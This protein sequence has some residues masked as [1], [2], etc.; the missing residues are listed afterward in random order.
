MA[1]QAPQSKA[2]TICQTHAYIF[3]NIPGTFFDFP[4]IYNLCYRSTLQYLFLCENDY[5][6]EKHSVLNSP[7]LLEMNTKH[8]CIM[9]LLAIQDLDNEIYHNAKV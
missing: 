6:E 5:F 7:L 3:Y 2:D 8:K 9:K 1:S 4:K